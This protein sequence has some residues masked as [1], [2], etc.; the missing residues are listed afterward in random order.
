MDKARKLG[1]MGNVNSGEVYFETFKEFEDLGMAP[2]RA[3]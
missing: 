3:I 1:F 2:K